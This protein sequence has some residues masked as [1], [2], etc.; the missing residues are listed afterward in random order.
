MAKVRNLCREEKRELKVLAQDF[1][2]YN[3]NDVKE[4]IATCGSYY[5]GHKKLMEIYNLVY[6]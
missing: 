3:R 4:I 1:G 5:E 6:M 2:L